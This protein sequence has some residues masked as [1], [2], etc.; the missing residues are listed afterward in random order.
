VTTDDDLAA[1]ALERG[2]ATAQQVADARARVATLRQVG[3]QADLLGALA[4]AL[5]PLAVAELRALAR[6][7]A[8]DGCETVV[9]APVEPAAP[10]DPASGA[11][12]STPLRGMPAPGELVGAYVVEREL[13]RG[14]MGVVYVARHT[15]LGRRVALKLR[16]PGE[17]QSDERFLREAQAAASLR[18]PAIVTVHDAGRDAAGRLWMAMD[19][20]QGEG[21]DRRLAR[22]PLGAREA[23]SLAARV[24]RGL[25]HAHARGVLH[26]DLKPSNILVQA[27]GAPLIVDFGLAKVVTGAEALTLE[28]QVLGTPGYMPPEQ[29]NAQPVDARADVW[30]L[31]ATLYHALVG[32]P[33]FA[34]VSGIALLAAVM[35]AEV[36]PPSARRPDVP[37]ALEAIVLRALSKRADDRQP[38]AA[39]LAAELES[40]LADDAAA[41]P[42]AVAEDLT[43][44]WSWTLA[45]AGA[46]PASADVQATYR[47]PGAESS[48]T[49]VL[50]PP[51]LGTPPPSGPSP[52]ELHDVLGRGGMGVVYR[53]R[54]RSLGREVAV[55]KVL[56]DG[57]RERFLAE[58]MVT[59]RLEH[60]NVVTVHD[61]GVADSGEL[62]MA[63]KL[64]EGTSWKRLLHPEMDDERARAARL[65]L[66]DHLRTLL[67][68]CNAVAYA[69]SRGIAH[70]DLKPENVMIGE[71]GEVSVMDW[72]LAVDFRGAPPDPATPADGALPHR[73]SIRGPCGTPAYMAPELA[74][75]EGDAIGAA[76]DVYLL[77]ATL[78]ELVC[79]RPPHRG[80]GLLQVVC[81][82]AS[83]VPAEL[84]PDV[85]AELREICRRAMASAPADRFPTALALRDALAAYLEHRESDL[86]ASAAA[87]RLARARTLDRDGAYADLAAAVAGYEQ[88]LVLWAGNAAARAGAQAAR[89][90]YAEVA[91]GHGDLGLAQAQLAAADGAD[92]A[93]ARL[94]AGIREA[95]AVRERARRNAQRLRVGLAAAL[96]TL[97]AGLATGYLLVSRARDRAVA[98]EAEARRE[99]DAAEEARRR[100]E[101]LLA[102]GLV[103]EGD[104]LAGLHRWPEAHERHAR[105]VALFAGLELDGRPARLG[106]WAT[107]LGARPPLIL[108]RGHTGPARGV[109]FVGS[110]V[111]SVGDDGTLRAWEAATGRALGVVAAHDG[112]AVGVAVSPT[113]RLV[114]TAGRDG[115]VRLWEPASL[116]AAWSVDAGFVPTCVVFSGT[117]RSVVAA[118]PDGALRF[119]SVQDGRV[120][121]DIDEDVAPTAALAI[122]PDGHYVFSAEPDGR[123]AYRETRDAAPYFRLEGPTTAAAALV[124]ARTRPLVAAAG[125]DG[126]VW[127]WERYGAGPTGLSRRALRAQAGALSAIQFAPGERLLLAAG[128]DGAL[129][130]WDLEREAVVSEAWCASAVEALAVSPAGD[131]VAAASED[132]AIALWDLG[133]AEVAPTGAER[134]REAL[135]LRSHPGPSGPAEWTCA[136]LSSDGALAATGAKDGL[137]VV[138]E[139][140]AGLPLLTLAGHRA[141]V[142]EVAFAPDGA[143]VS[144]SAD[145]VARVWDLLEERPRASL[146]GGPP[147][148]A[149]IAAIASNAALVALVAPDGASRVW[150]LEGAARLLA[151]DGPA[152]AAALHPDG[153]RLLVSGGGRLRVRDLTSG[154][155]TRA[156]DGPDATCLAV[157][158]DG[159]RALSGHGDGVVR[160]WDL[161]RGA[162]VAL[163]RGHAGPVHRV[164]FEGAD[165]ASSAGS[166][167]TWRLWDLAAEGGPRELRAFARHGDRVLG[168]ALAR[169]GELAL[170]ASSDGAIVWDLAAGRLAPHVDPTGAPV[171]VGRVLAERGSL[172][173][174]VDL[175]EQAR[176]SGATLRAD[177]ELT[178]LRGHWELGRAGPALAAGRRLPGDALPLALARRELSRATVATGTRV[179]ELADPVTALAF[180]PDGR[181][182]AVGADD[183]RVLLVD[184]ALG[185]TLRVVDAHDSGLRALA[186]SRDGRRLASGSRHQSVVVW[187]VG[188]EVTRRRELQLSAIPT[189]LAFAS[190]GRLVVA[191]S[192]GVVV[193]EPF[194]A[195]APE[196]LPCGPRLRGV[197]LAPDGRTLF[198]CGDEVLHVFDLAPGGAPRTLALEPRALQVAVVGDRLAVLGRDSELRVVDAATGRA[199]GR[200]FEPIDRCAGLVPAGPDRVAWLD[201]QGQAR[202]W[203]V[204]RSLLL[205]DVQ[206]AA[207]AL[208]LAVAPDHAS[209]AVGSGDGRATV[210][211]LTDS[212]R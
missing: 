131:R 187:D 95:H 153:G 39:S 102:H 70:C 6:G 51:A 159:A 189:A 172:R 143:L 58:A 17:P 57:A 93:A 109:A 136:A 125:R 47:P 175:L 72:G 174:A 12:A 119:W 122:S 112:P 145:G 123:V 173:A 48:P 113:A 3:M 61:L 41:R 30:A 90:T 118:A 114:A 105:A 146:E 182:L 208:S 138:W 85:P 127:L 32:Q 151:A 166:D 197:A 168:L 40:W 110:T 18:H 69:H 71:F 132:G 202:V 158:P 65:G 141:A 178:L 52:Y 23:A 7:G 55:K 142:T 194:G 186:W 130:V 86:I 56:D 183:G 89:L 10:A 79:G 160:L 140:R 139:P 196:E 190:D 8:A 167:G 185:R 111:C 11:P 144:T 4:A 24:A 156:F 181:T 205:A 34:G 96:A 31:G 157:S 1:A 120:V 154:A 20:V 45:G 204:A 92:P 165:L 108:A 77:G 164:V 42:A 27:G 116:R 9:A 98:S 155:A 106:L 91:L 161:A 80:K 201:G 49:V 62:L 148:V 97:V 54:Q 147:G 171:E 53:A 200:P 29:A 75:G 5:S 124:H 179:A 163:L 25:E 35:R 170:T 21:L 117:G 82:A 115:R 103:S 60:P 209:F 149:A 188:P 212:D 193:C 13:G 101:T 94:A 150:P 99:R 22:G 78:Y 88:A 133:L 176:A 129:R 16:L 67:A 162:E 137:V 199:L 198:A 177:D 207:S 206:L 64:V 211:T 210:F 2:L 169:A 43:L 63:M 84:A 135:P 191:S 28:G 33:P 195:D 68:V 74:N 81:A 100:A 50:L 83:G 128:R 203:D 14:G 184:P 73:S 107:Q 121:I 59:G 37:T 180:A 38:S 15:L 66:V 76:T 26:R 126:A 87:E 44:A 152:G 104:A 46:D 19:L 134:P 192:R 36:V